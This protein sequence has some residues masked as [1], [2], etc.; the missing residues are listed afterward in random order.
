MGNIGRFWLAFLLILV[1]MGLAAIPL[2]AIVELLDGDLILPAV[3]IFSVLLF[4]SFP[5]AVDRIAKIAFFFKGEGSPVPEMELRRQILEIN[6]Q[7]N[8]PVVVEEK[9][10]KLI[11]T[12]KYLDAK[13]W[14]IMRKRGVQ[15]SFRLIIKFDEKRHRVTLIDVMSTVSWGA[16]P[17]SVKVHS[18]FF[19]GVYLGYS[20]GKAWGIKENFTLGKIYDFKFN[21]E[22]IHNPVMNTIL[23]AGWDVR[24]GCF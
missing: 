12:W 24:F 14:E 20:I 2:Y 19:R 23:R 13:W 17:A 21:S 3:L 22:E 8:L 18:T 10:K 1:Y 11:V 7:S 5:W 9:G 15:E 4:L 6:A 16:G